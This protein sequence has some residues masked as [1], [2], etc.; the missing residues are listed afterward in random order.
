MTVW[1]RVVLLFNLTSLQIELFVLSPFHSPPPPSNITTLTHGV[2]KSNTSDTPL[3]SAVL[4]G[5]QAGLHCFFFVINVQKEQVIFMI[6]NPISR[7]SVMVWTASARYNLL[8]YLLSVSKYSTYPPDISSQA[9][10]V[11]VSNRYE[12]QLGIRAGFDLVGAIV[13]IR[14]SDSTRHLK[15]IVL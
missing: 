8:I 9:I 13:F 3:C 12:L 1:F 15:V 2:T 5:E 11:Q 7:I 14:I 10:R 6:Y 4:W